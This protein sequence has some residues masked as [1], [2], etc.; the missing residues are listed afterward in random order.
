M[1]FINKH[2]P[3]PRKCR[4][5]QLICNI[6]ITIISSR[7]LFFYVL[8]YKAKIEYEFKNIGINV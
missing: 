1:Q 2:L 4:L 3:N 5:F 8:E 7:I 6:S